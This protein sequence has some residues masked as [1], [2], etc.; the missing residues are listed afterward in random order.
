MPHMSVC[1]IVDRSPL[2]VLVNL[3]KVPIVV[4]GDVLFTGFGNILPNTTY[5]SFD[6]QKLRLIVPSVNSKLHERWSAS[7]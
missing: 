4:Q 3:L 6:T 1:Y 5:T 2:K 7:S